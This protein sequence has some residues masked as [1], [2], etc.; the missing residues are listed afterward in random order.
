MIKGLL[1]AAAAAWACAG[2]AADIEIGKI[3]LGMSQQEFA[4]AYPRGIEGVIALAGASARKELGAP[5]VRFRDGR[6]E[7]FAAYFR[8]Q[9]FDRIR[10]SVVAGAVPVQCRSHEVVSVCYDAQGS[11]VLTRSG[12]TTMLLLQTAR[13]AAEAQGALIEADAAAATH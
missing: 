5:A 1:L 6:L 2:H 10:R 4:R 13:A 8:A 11:F 3:R 9:D 12:D 7:Q